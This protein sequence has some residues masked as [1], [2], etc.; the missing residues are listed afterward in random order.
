M[1]QDIS[2]GMAIK[3]R[4]EH[5]DGTGK[6]IYAEETRNT[7]YSLEY[8]GFRAKWCNK[9]R[10]KACPEGFREGLITVECLAFAIRY[11]YRPN[12]TLQQLSQIMN[13]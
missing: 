2:P 6:L 12:L 7:D 8:D 3:N 1:I 4:M 5:R 11:G 9:Y 13:L 10:D